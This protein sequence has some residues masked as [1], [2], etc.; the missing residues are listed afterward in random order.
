HTSPLATSTM[1]LPHAS[2]DVQSAEQLS[3]STWLPSSQTSPLAVSTMWL[4]QVS[5]DAQSPEQPSPEV[6]LPS[7][8]TS[9]RDVSTRPSPHRG[10]WQY[11][12]HGAFGA[13]ALSAPAS[14]CS[15]SWR[16]RIPSPQRAS[17]QSCWQPSPSTWLPSSHCSPVAGSTIPL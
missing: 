15:L 13:L 4:P 12:R 10:A 16:S 9:P 14:P 11:R 2:L 6:L 17:R 7:S 3:P 8:H 1:W 5:S